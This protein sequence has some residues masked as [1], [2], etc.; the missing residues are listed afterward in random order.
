MT[1][2]IY[3]RVSSARQSG[4]DHASLDAQIEHC[5]AFARQQYPGVVQVVVSETI[6]GRVLSK[7]TK[8]GTLLQRLKKGDVFIF[9]NVSRFSRDSGNAIGALSKLGQLGVRIHSVFDKLTYPAD[10]ASFR[11]L[12]VEA[13]EESDV[14]SERVRGALSYIR[15]QNGHI[16]TA[17][18]GY[19]VEREAPSQGHSYRPRR[20][21]P[22]PEEMEIVREI[23]RYVD[24]VTELDSQVNKRYAIC[25]VIADT[26][27]TSNRSCRGQPWTPER[28]KYI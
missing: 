15:Q 8:L 14:I 26:F 24:N 27:N 11:R 9:Y 28:V 7:Q 17:P 22:N 3:S 16:G 2:V 25:N 21:V 1:I 19:K 13:N 18:Y 23:I 20:L 6:S 10:R 12:L 4:T 5:K